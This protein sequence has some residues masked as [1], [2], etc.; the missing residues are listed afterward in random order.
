M[1]TNDQIAYFV[2]L[3]TIIVSALGIINTKRLGKKSDAIVAKPLVTGTTASEYFWRLY[4]L[5]KI[6]Y[7]LR[8]NHYCSLGAAIFYLSYWAT[9]GLEWV[10]N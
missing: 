2:D 8:L 1:T 6:G 10:T 9:R 4:E 7:Q 3:V 5:E